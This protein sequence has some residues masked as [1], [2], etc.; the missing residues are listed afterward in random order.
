M[1]ES[2]E[3]LLRAWTFIDFGGTLISVI[4]EVGTLMSVYSIHR[5]PIRGINSVIKKLAR[6]E[7]SKSKPQLKLCEIPS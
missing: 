3:I 1:H 7:N 2:Q 4:A 6:A 5:H